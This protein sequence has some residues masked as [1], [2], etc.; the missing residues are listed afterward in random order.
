MARDAV[1]QLSLEGLQSDRRF[2][3]GFV[4]GRVAKGYGEARIRQ[5]LRCK[6]ISREDV[7]EV[8]RAYDWDGLLAEVY[9]KKYGHSAPPSIKERAARLRFL[10]QKG[11]AASAIGSLLRHLHHDDP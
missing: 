8:L 2:L 11:F 4:R 6:G 1:E 7:D 10:Q 3:E 5:E 9:V